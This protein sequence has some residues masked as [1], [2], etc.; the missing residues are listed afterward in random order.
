ML[1]GGV[2]MDDYLKI[3]P[4]LPDEDKLSFVGFLNQHAAVE[5]ETGNE[6]NTVLTTQAE[7][8]GKIPLIFDVSVSSSE[9]G[10][11]EDWSWIVTKIQ[12]LRLLKNHVFKNTLTEKCLNLFQQP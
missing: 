10:D 1:D 3:G 2:E 11:P 4:R 6:V 7:S 9:N 8:N 5:N 12:E